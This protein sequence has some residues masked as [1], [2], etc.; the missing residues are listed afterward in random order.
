MAHISE[1]FHGSNYVRIDVFCQD[2]TAISLTT[3]SIYQ[4]I[5]LQ[6]VNCILAKIC[7]SQ[8]CKVVSGRLPD[9]HCRVPCHHPHPNCQSLVQR[10]EGKVGWWNTAAS[11]I[12]AK[13]AKASNP[14]HQHI[15]ILLLNT[16]GNKL[17]LLLH[18]LIFV[19]HPRALIVKNLQKQSNWIQLDFAAPPIHI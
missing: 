8:I 13:T 19:F 4:S 2:T 9:D 5:P 10:W 14:R 16:W 1:N 6:S 3:T 18:P 17:L 11:G 15:F 7:P 12:N